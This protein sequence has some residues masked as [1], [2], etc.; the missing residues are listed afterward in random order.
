[1]EQVNRIE[2]LY[3]K[4]AEDNIL[5]ILMVDDSK[6]SQILSTLKSFDFYQ[7]SHQFI[8]KAIEDLHK[9]GKPT[10]TVSVQ[11]LLKFNGEL[12]RVGGNS[13]LLE[14]VDNYITS[15]NWEQLTKIIIKFSKLRYLM[16]LC[17][18]AIT[19]LEN[20]EDVDDIAGTL[21]IKA[22]EIMTRTSHT[23]FIGLDTGF[24]EFWDD[25]EILYESET[26]TLGLP[27]GIK[28]LDNQLSGLIGG[29]MYLLGAR[30]SMGKSALAQQIAEYI[31][32][33][34]QVLFFSLEMSTKEYTSRSIYRRSGFNQEH[35]TIQKDRQEEILQAFTKAGDELSN[36]KLHII[37]DSNATLKTVE[38]NI[39]Q[40]KQQFGSC[41]LIVIDYLQLMEPVD[42]RITDDYKIVTDNSQGL[43]KLARKYNIPILALCQLSRNLEGRADK[44]PILA[45]LRDSGSLEQDAD[46]V[47]FLYRDEIYNPTNAFSRGKADLYIAKNRAGRRGVNIRFIFNATKVEF[48]EEL[49]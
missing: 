12:D 38:K 34:K 19:R 39:L 14:L 22:N 31:A 44:R 6:V 4:E 9:Q 2:D 40:C 21:S 33:T 37:D 43:K 24:S 48:T 41:D 26:G 28:G 13:K 23:D 20:K 35:L 5:S 1:M 42:K 49:K 25:V 32:K 8:Y 18:D 10:D 36:L 16:N 47:M 3:S 27:T 17:R 46:V 45:D 29:K 30:P 7:K 11:E 15:K